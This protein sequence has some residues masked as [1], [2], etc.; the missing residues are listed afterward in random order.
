MQVIIDPWP[1]TRLSNVAAWPACSGVD[2]PHDSMASIKD[3]T[4][5]AE[6]ERRGQCETRRNIINSLS[7]L[8][9]FVSII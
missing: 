8:I 1:T 6:R 7:R 9:P 4:L 2:R 5:A 3:R